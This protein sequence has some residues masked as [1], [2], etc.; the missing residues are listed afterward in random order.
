M[1]AEST[2][3]SKVVQLPRRELGPSDNELSV[4]VVKATAELQKAMDSAVLAGLIV[5][6][7]FQKLGTRLE[8]YGV[9]SESYVCTVHTYRQLS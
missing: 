3:A 2:P 1:P 8:S 9:T 4:K 6:P 7:S 5:E